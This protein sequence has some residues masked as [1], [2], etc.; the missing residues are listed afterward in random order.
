[1]PDVF[2]KAKRSQVMSRIRGRGNKETELALMRLFRRQGITGW[3]RHPPVFGRP[4]FVFVKAQ[5]EIPLSARNDKHGRAL[6]RKLKLAVFVDGCFWHNC[7]KHSN[8]PR[9]NRAF[10]KRKLESNHRRDRLVG[11]TLRARGWR[12]LR[13]WQHELSRRNEKRLLRRFQQALAI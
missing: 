13:V 12:V 11:R 2:S 8:L 3:R 6:D 7:P 5:S 4:D 10:W 1:M 9:N